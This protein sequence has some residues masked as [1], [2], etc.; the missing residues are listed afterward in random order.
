MSVCV[1]VC[2]C[3]CVISVC[4]HVRTNVVCMYKCADDVNIMP[5]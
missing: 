5:V 3:V 2:V 1:C 4:M